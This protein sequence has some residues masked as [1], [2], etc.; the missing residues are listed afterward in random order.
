MCMYTIVTSFSRIVPFII[1]SIMLHLYCLEC[2]LFFTNYASATKESMDNI[3]KIFFNLYAIFTGE[4][5]WSIFMFSV[6]MLASQNKYTK[7]IVKSVF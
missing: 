7:Q 2:R 6:G 1:L 3:S 4:V 5:T